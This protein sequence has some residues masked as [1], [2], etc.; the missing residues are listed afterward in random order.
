MSQPA[1]NDVV[2]VTIERT[3]SMTITF[4]DG[5]VCRFGVGELRAACPCATCRGFRERGGVAWPRAAWGHKL[6]VASGAGVR[7]E[8]GIPVQV[9]LVPM[10]G[11][12]VAQGFSGVVNG[13]LDAAGA[14]EA[15][16]SAQ[17]EG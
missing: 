12:R 6:D 4:D 1:E 5:L 2:D 7:F 17:H 13:P 8:P 14:L 11:N 3:E 16:L 15:A 9:N 10:A